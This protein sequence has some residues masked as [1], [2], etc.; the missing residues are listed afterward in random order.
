MVSALSAPLLTSLMV[1]QLIGRTVATS[2]TWTSVG[3][4][5]YNLEFARYYNQELAWV[6]GSW[7]HPDLAESG[8]DVTCAQME[9]AVTMNSDWEWDWHVSAGNVDCPSLPSCTWTITSS[10]TTVT[11]VTTATTNATT[12][13]TTSGSTAAETAT[14]STSSRSTTTETATSSAT[15]GSTTAKSS[16]TPGGTTT[17]YNSPMAEQEQG[18][19]ASTV[20]VAIIIVI[21][22]STFLGCGTMSALVCLT[23]RRLGRHKPDASPANETND[24]AEETN[25]SAEETEDSAEETEDGPAGLLESMDF[26]FI[27]VDEVMRRPA[28]SPLPRHQECRD[29]GMLVKKHMT[30]DGVLSG[31]FAGEMAAVSHRWPVPEHFDPECVKLRKLQEVL[32][33]NPSIKFLWIDWV[34]APQWH[35]GGRTDE[36]EQEFRMILENIL[37]FIFLGCKVIVLYER[38]YNQRFWPNVEC[39]IST[40]TPTEDGLVP[41]NEDCLRVQVYGI[42]SASGK[43]KASRAQV[44]KFWHS[45]GTQEAIATLSHDDILVTNAKDK[46]INLKVVALLDDN[47]KDHFALHV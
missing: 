8:G 42:H 32:E 7:S 33:N 38:I 4:N 45:A 18:S 34:C 11:W 10:V 19:E 39:W 35:G 46:E 28:D 47:I 36:E 21:V 1:F 6:G 2:C 9:M 22:I 23:R 44:L 27:P 15:S 40:K 16:S 20:S 26:W 31:Q 29:S 24:S 43:D 3:A 25:D 37:P 5:G 13:S 14:N 17:T 12:D 30:L 41:A